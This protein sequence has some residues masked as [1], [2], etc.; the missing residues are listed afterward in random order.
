MWSIPTAQPFFPQGYPKS[1]GP[2]EGALC[3]Q[4]EWDRRGNCSRRREPRRLIRW[5]TPTGHCETTASITLSP[6]RVP[7]TRQV[8]AE[9]RIICGGQE[10][11]YYMNNKKL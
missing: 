3:T 6:E 10:F 1:Y 5:R 8:Y 9:I 4:T 11:F 7:K 2:G